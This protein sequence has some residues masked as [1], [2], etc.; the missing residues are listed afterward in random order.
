MK[1]GWSLS[2]LMALCFVCVVAIVG[3]GGGDSSSS[4]SDGT[5]ADISGTW[6]FVV[7][8]AGT[9]MATLS[10]S[11]P[12]V[13]GSATYE[14]TPVSVTGTVTGNGVNLMFSISGQPSALAVGNV[15]G[16]QIS[17]AWTTGDESGTFTA[18]K[19]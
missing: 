8:G 7:P 19:Q 12:N 5:T 2:L 17:G 15:S 9:Y 11:G 14:G 13:S 18:T 6:A 10:Q 3:C 1:F 16:N 4:A